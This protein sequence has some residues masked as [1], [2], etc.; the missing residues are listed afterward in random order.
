[1]IATDQG[2]DE[3]H[4]LRGAALPPRGLGLPGQEAGVR[5]LSAALSAW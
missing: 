3:Y 4:H 5:G 2:P 1:M